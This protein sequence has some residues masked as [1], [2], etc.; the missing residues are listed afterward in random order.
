VDPL[1][2]QRRAIEA[3]I[4]PA[5][6][7]APDHSSSWVGAGDHITVKKNPTYFQKGLPHLDSITYSS[8]PST[9]AVL[10]RS[11]AHCE[12]GWADAVPLRYPR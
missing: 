7:S 6:R 1:V 4:R 9:R 12:I 10:M 3:A 2:N 11:P 8:L 5:S